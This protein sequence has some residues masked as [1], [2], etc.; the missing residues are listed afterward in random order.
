MNRQG[1]DAIGKGLWLL[2][3]GGVLSVIG[4]FIPNLEGILALGA[5]AL[6]LLGLNAAG[7]EDSGYRTAFFLT[8]ANLAVQ[9]L[10]GVLSVLAEGPLWTLANLA[11][12]ALSCLCIYYVCATTA[13]LLDSRDAA[14]AR[15][16]ELV[17]KI[18]AGSFG[19]LA[20]CAVLALVP[21]INLLAGLTAIAV[22]LAQTVTLAVYLIFLY[23]ASGVFKNW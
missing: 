2:F 17:W 12:V 19:V 20:V 6:D 5:L 7:R 14:L 16:G 15:R 8:L 3:W 10:S 18:T 11:S 13:R 22:A 21:L 9:F 1:Y 4:S 23:Q